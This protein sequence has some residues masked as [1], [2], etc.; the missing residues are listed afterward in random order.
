MKIS[1]D[2][3]L[4]ALHG[5]LHSWKATSV[6]SRVSQLQRLTWVVKVRE[7]YIDNNYDDNWEKILLSKIVI[8]Q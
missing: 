6:S 8:Y 1:V 5:S 4:V 2:T 7:S 3:L